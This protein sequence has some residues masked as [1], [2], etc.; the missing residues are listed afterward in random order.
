MKRLATIVA[1]L[2]LWSVFPVQAGEVPH[3][4]AGFVIGQNVAE[5][6]DRLQ[7]DTRLP[8]RYQ[9][10]LQEVEIKPLTGFK[11]GLIAY[12]NCARPGR[13]VRIKMKYA[14]A[15]RSFYDA[16]L[17]RVERRFGKPTAYDGDPF[18]IVIEWKWS[19]IDAD[20]DQITLHLSHNSRD[21][22]E[23]FGNA[24]KLTLANGV[25]EERQCSLAATPQQ[26]EPETAP[27]PPLKSMTA[28]DWKQFVPH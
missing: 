10:Y 26:R 3:G 17:A 20:G 25:D 19:F 4:V 9:E 15:S 28:E 6:S 11:S 8:L 24:V 7:M 18:H 2:T 22:E 23:K 13:I 27:H 21:T 5:F 12:G 14:D 1:L 16:L